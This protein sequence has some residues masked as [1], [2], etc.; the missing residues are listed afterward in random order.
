M[1]ITQYGSYIYPPLHGNSET[2]G[3][4]RRSTQSSLSNG[5][6]DVDTIGSGPS[7]ETGNTITKSFR[8]IESSEAAFNAALTDFVG[9]MMLSQEDFRHGAR[10]IIATDGV[11]L[12]ATRAKVISPDYGIQY[13]HENNFWI[14]IT[15][16]FERTSAKWWTYT[17]LLQLGDNLGTLGDTDAAGYTLGQ[18]V[19]EQSLGSALTTFTVTNNG[20]A[21]ILNGLIE[22][23]GVINT[24]VVTN[25]RN[26]H[27]FTLNRSLDP[28]DRFTIAPLSRNCKFNGSPGFYPDLTLGQERAQLQPMTLEPGDNQITI[29][30]SGTPACTFR[31]YFADTWRR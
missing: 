18:G 1:F 31:Y 23:D 11:T 20:N 30:A 19:L 10:L 27:T 28:G 29:I 13:F 3:A 15:Q 9:Q 21:R 5:S 4:A 16:V 24:P 17:Q 25:D 7:P 12:Y 22:F 14:D 2:G 8:I 6:G 26:K